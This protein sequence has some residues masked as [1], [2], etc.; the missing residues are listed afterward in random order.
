MRRIHARLWTRL[1]YQLRAGTVAVECL[2]MSPG[3]PEQL[4]QANQSASFAPA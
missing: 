3:K 4:L 1:I 2:K